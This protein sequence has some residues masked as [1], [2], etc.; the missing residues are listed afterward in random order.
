MKTHG[1]GKAQYPKLYRHFENAQTIANT[2]NR[3]R[4]YV[5]KALKTGFTERERAL[6]EDHAGTRLFD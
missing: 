3:S 1:P 5:F 4:A 6:L 2:I